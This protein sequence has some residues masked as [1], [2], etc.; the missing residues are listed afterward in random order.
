MAVTFEELIDYRASQTAATVEDKK[1][2]A[3]S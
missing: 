1:R 3:V 2:S